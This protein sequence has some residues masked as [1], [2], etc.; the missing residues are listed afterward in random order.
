ML[1]NSRSCAGAGRS[2]SNVSSARLFESVKSVE[3]VAFLPFSPIRSESGGKLLTPTSDYTRDRRH[4]SNFRQPRVYYQDDTLDRRR[5]CFRFKP[6]IRLLA[7]PGAEIF[8]TMDTGGPSFH[9]NSGWL[10]RLFRLGL[11]YHNLP[12]DDRR[13]LSRPIPGRQAR[14]KSL[15]QAAFQS[16]S[17]YCPRACPGTCIP[18]CRRG[19]SF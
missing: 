17:W 5:I 10:P 15:I 12:G 7:C 14:R 16:A 2:S 18:G 9:P 11:A 13:L 6:P 1:K 4:S 8:S 19:D 3:S